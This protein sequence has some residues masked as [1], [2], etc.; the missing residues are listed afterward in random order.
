MRHEQRM[1]ARA[2]DD[3]LEGAGGLGTDPGRVVIN[4]ARGEL[5]AI[6]DQDVRGNELGERPLRSDTG[7]APQSIPFASRVRCLVALRAYRRKT[8]L[9]L[10]VLAAGPASN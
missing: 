8:A 6:P 2:P 5:D 7:P 9:R 4:G 10:G 1:V 3:R